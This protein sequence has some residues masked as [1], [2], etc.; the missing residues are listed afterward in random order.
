MKNM[1]RGKGV[2]IGADERF[3]QLKEQIELVEIFNV[4]LIFHL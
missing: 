1:L 3:R 4:L 2:V